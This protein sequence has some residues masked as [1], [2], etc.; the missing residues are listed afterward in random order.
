MNARIGLLTRAAATV[1]ALGVTF[2]GALVLAAAPAQAQRYVTPYGFEGSVF[3]TRVVSGDAGLRSGRSA[4]SPLGC[5]K[6]AGITRGNKVASVQESQQIDIGAVTS[7]NTTYRQAKRGVVGVRGVNRIAD[8]TLR[9]SDG[10]ALALAGLATRTHVWRRDGARRFGASTDFSSSDVSVT[11]AEDTPVEGPLGDLV[12][13]AQDGID[14]V[15]AALQEN[16]GRIAIPGLGVV[17]QGSAYTIER[18]GIGVASGYML[19]VTLTDGTEVQIGRSWSKMVRDLP[20]GPMGGGATAVEID[21][22]AGIVQSGRIATQPLPCEGTH[23]KVRRSPLA[24]ADPGN[25]D[26]LVVDGARASAYGV[27]R[28][29]GAARGWT[30]ATVT[31]AALGDGAVVLGAVTGR[32]NVSQSADGRVR[33]N[34]AGTT[35]GSLTV[36]GTEQAIPRDARSFAIP[37]GTARVEVNLVERTRRSIRVT[38]ARVTLFEGTAGEISVRLGTAKA[39][40]RRK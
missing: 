6:E 15:L 23:G 39:L 14:G 31:R 10:A 34:A 18:A 25:A 36:N 1:T 4:W 20:A 37:G 16:G 30:E 27:Q 11:V 9:G 7:T 17:R 24:G 3:G 22:L 19:R 8:V 35:I 32:A 12:Q 38:A 26:A 2:S 40:I 5:T 28:S 21:A 29:T 33:V 13:G